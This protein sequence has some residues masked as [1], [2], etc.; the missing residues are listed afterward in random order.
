MNY[1][2][3]FNL[4][5]F[6][7]FSFLFCC[8]WLV[9]CGL[10]T[11]PHNLPEVIP[12]STFTNFKV[13]QRDQRIRLSLTIN[14]NERKNALMK[15][16]DDLDKQDYFL[17][18]EQKFK[19]GCQDCEIEKIPA[20]RI[21]FSSDSFIRQEDNLYYYLEL[22]QSDLK[23]HQFQASHFGPEDEI[24]S[25]VKILTFRQSN[26][27][28]KVPVPNLQ[29]VQIEDEKKIIRFSFGKVVLKKLT[30]IND[31]AEK[32]LEQNKQQQI[33]SRTFVLKLSWP[34]LSYTGSK[35]L[36]G[37]GDYFEGQEFFKVHLYRT[38]SGEAWPE[39]P[40][41]VKTIPNNHYLDRLKYFIPPATYPHMADTHPDISPPKLSFYIDLHGQKR[42]TWLYN[43]RLVDR[44][45]N[46]SAASE[47]IKFQSPETMILGQNFGQKIFVP[48]SD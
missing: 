44:F 16:D 40:I 38:L 25:P 6:Y 26:Q 18:Q 17:I 32:L 9:S 31:E 5:K 13:Q 24:L 8:G 47:T 30:V 11:S 42:D 28:P 39:T 37:K 1:F 15:L 4:G 36:K 12:K 48:L 29:I 20:L 10:R 7:F 43:L 46:E 23:I 27:Y 3:T 45:G 33:E 2:F 14:G 22:P 34:I 35:R 41:N 21:L 19:I